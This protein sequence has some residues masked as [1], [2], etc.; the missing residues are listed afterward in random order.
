MIFNKENTDNQ[1]TKPTI[2][3]LYCSY[4]SVVNKR[5]KAD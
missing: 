2:F 4:F 5:D 1:K 3:N